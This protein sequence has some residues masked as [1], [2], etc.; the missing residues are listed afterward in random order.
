M[1]SKE[2]IKYGFSGELLYLE[3]TRAFVY[4]KGTGEPVVCFHG[5]PAT[6]YAYRNIISE[7][8]HQGF[9]GISF[10]LLGMGLS[11]RPSNFEYSWT[12]LGEWVLHVIQKLNLGRFHVI[13][14]DIGGPIACEVIHKIPHQIASVTLLNTP[15]TNLSEF[16]KPFPMY[17]YEK[18]GLGELITKMTNGFFFKLLMHNRGVSK[19]EQFGLEHAKAYVEFM[20]GHD[21]AKAF[22][23]IMRSFEATQEK[24]QLYIKSLKKLLVPKQ[25]IW[26]TY[27]KALTLKNYGLPLKEALEIDRIVELPGL[28]F[29]QE[30]YANE[31]VSHFV[32]M[33]K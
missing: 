17:L 14:H 28:H 20:K 8:D 25:I 24:S 9:R 6:S 22:L 12:N 31:I 10:D 29:L 33:V 30:D 26:G 15:L 4:E 11:D 13:L 18:R 1:K 2:A 23:K 19:K 5:V 27:D 21:N 32:K 3:D 16:K 7:L